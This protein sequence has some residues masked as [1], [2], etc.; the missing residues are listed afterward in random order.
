MFS[1]KKPGKPANPEKELRFTRAH[2]AILFWA[3]ATVFFCVSMWLFLASTPYLNPLDW[4]TR[5]VGSVMWGFIPLFPMLLSVW[6]SVHLTRHAFIILTPLGIELFPFWMPKKNLNVFYW[7][8]IERAEVT[9][10]EKMLV[11]FFKGEGDSRVYISLTPI[12]VS[13]RPLLRR[14]I[15]GRM[16]ASSP[17]LVPPG[18]A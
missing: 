6:V 3:L 5:R 13:Q 4:E 16:A 18:G 7:A 1:A 8:E 10:D 9:E 11:I 12:R 15:E 17:E 14:A 2:Q